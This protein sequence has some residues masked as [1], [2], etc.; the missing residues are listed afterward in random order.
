MR[1]FCVTSLPWHLGFFFPFFQE[2]DSVTVVIMLYGNVLVFGL[3]IL[4]I[5]QSVN[6]IKKKVN[7]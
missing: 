3:T 6:F 2:Q 1:T 4:D 7:T 5:N